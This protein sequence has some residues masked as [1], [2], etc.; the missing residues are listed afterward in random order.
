MYLAT[1]AFSNPPGTG[2]PPNR[3]RGGHAVGETK[4]A[5]TKPATEIVAQYERDNVALHPFFLRMRRRSFDLDAVYVLLL[6][7]REGIVTHFTRRLANV[8]SRVEDLRIRSVLGKQ[9]NDELGNGDPA[10][11]HARLFD[12]MIEGI[13]SVHQEAEHR[14]V[15]RSLEPGRILGERLQALYTQSSAMAGVGAAMAIE[16]IGK[17]ADC[18]LGVELGRQAQVPRSSLAWLDL[19]QEL[20]Q[21]HS[22]ESL[23]LAGFIPPDD[24]SLREA[25]AGAQEC[26]AAVW[27]FLDHMYELCYG[28]ADAD[29]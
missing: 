25:W 27:Q 29:P 6:N 8:I 24:E 17:H 7:T 11:A 16:I 28:T 10:R 14:R 13:A 5:G 1:E 22:A 3:A 18:F 21:D 20:E 9:L 12:E 4:R 2:W 15:R 26:A 23:D 19:H